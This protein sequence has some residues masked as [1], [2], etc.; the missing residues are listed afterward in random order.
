MCLFFQNYF[1][2]NIGQ[3]TFHSLWTK[4][5]RDRVFV[6]PFAFPSFDPAIIHVVVH[7]GVVDKLSI[8]A[9]VFL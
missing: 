2:C 6:S 3:R 9:S 8:V 5:A 1:K 7:P 4:K